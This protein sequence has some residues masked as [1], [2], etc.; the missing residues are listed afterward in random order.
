[1]TTLRP[2]VDVLVIQESVSVPVLSIHVVFC[3]C[4]GVNAVEGGF[5]SGTIISYIEVKNLLFLMMIWFAVEDNVSVGFC[6]YNLVK[7]RI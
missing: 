5:C 1:M 3:P 6:C 4:W 2:V 7:S